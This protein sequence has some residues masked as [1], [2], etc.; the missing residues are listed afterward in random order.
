[1][2][3]LLRREPERIEDWE[4]A[5]ECDGTTPTT[6]VE[7]SRDYFEI[8]GQRTYVER[9]SACGIDQ[10]PHAPHRV[11][12]AAG[13]YRFR[14]CRRCGHVDREVVMHPLSAFD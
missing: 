1:V 12:H 6:K 4:E 5:T 9:T 7:A 14:T 8:T 10:P 11:V 13:E 3:S 2:L